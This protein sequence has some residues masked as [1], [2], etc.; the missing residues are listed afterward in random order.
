MVLNYLQVA[1]YQSSHAETRPRRTQWKR[2]KYS[3]IQNCAVR[4]TDLGLRLAIITMAVGNDRWH[5]TAS[6]LSPTARIFTKEVGFDNGNRSD[7]QWRWEIPCQAS[8]DNH[9]AF[10]TS[11]NLHSTIS[12]DPVLR[13][14][15]P[16]KQVILRER[17]ETGLF[18]RWLRFS[19]VTVWK[20]KNTFVRPNA[21]PTDTGGRTRAMPGWLALMSRRWNNG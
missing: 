18:V 10:Q 19:S 17:W 14:T 12:R 20:C 16:R 13:T 9:T 5:T 1:S 11:Q 6:R 15:L 3:I 21:C 7:R 2:V 8:T 4:C